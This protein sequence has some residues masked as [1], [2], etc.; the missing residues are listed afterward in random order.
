VT[1]FFLLLSEIPFPPLELLLV[2]WSCRMQ[3]FFPIDFSAAL[4]FFGARAQVCPA[5]QFI[6]RR[7]KASSQRFLFRFGTWLRSLCRVDLSVLPRADLVFLSPRPRVFFLCAVDLQECFSFLDL[8]SLQKHLAL[9]CFW[10]SFGC[11]RFC[12]PSF[13]V[14]ARRQGFVACAEFLHRFFLSPAA[15]QLC[16]QVRFP[17][18]RRSCFSFSL[19]VL[20]LVSTRVG[21]PSSI[22]SVSVVCYPLSSVVKARPPLGPSLGAMSL[23]V[24][25]FSIL[26][27]A[28]LSFLVFVVV[29]LQVRANIFLEPRD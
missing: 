2:R 14:R 5:V 12:R 16:R 10:S 9:F 13:S 19:A 11:R 3:R 18:G 29:L 22:C 8:W 1:P 24:D 17:G 27:V 6:A 7:A 28:L 15:F 4:V 20:A 21:S 26:S 25:S 23:L